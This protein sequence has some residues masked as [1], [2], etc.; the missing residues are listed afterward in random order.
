MHSVGKLTRRAARDTGR[1]AAVTNLRGAETPGAGDAVSRH[2]SI[3]SAVGQTASARAKR[4]DSNVLLDLP[5]PIQ[6]RV[7][8]APPVPDHPDRC[9]RCEGGLPFGAESVTLLCG[10]CRHQ[11]RH[12]LALIDASALRKPA[13]LL[14][15]SQRAA[16]Q[17]Q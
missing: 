3:D 16:D 4:A 12:Q 2:R 7:A 13:L 11:Q 10:Q 9:G 17:L 1:V 6:L 14:I 8:Q 15:C 5:G